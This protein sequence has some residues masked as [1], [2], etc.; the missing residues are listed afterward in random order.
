[1]VLLKNLLKRAKT[2]KK[3]K[4]KIQGTKKSNLTDFV[5]KQNIHTRGNLTV[6]DL[7][8][9]IKKYK[10]VKCPGMWNM[11]KKELI[12]FMKKNKYP[13]KIEFSDKFNK[14]EYKLTKYEQLGK[15]NRIRSIKKKKKR[16]I[17]ERSDD[18]KKNIKYYT[19]KPVLEKTKTKN[20]S[21]IRRA[22]IKKE[23]VKYRTKKNIKRTKRK[24]SKRK[25]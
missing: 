7:R 2:Y 4:C 9:I 24:I 15:L 6:V 22:I 13:I 16:Y 12:D 17:K 21:S 1:M 3:K 5:I 8:R 25:L 14:K 20:R 19:I 23:N 10:K 11:K 18:T